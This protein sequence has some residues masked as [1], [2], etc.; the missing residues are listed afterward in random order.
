MSFSSKTKNELSRIKFDD[1]CCQRSELSAL[2]R[3]S[4]SIQ[5][6]GFKKVNL[7]ITTE[8]AAVARH[9]FTLFKKTFNIHAEVHVKKN[10]NLKKSNSYFIFFE[11]AMELL[12]TLEIIK[13]KNGILEINEDVPEFVKKKE[14]CKRA[15][16]RG[17]FIGGGSISDPE[18]AYHLELNLHSEKF[19]SMLKAFIEDNYRIFPKEIIRKNNYV[20]Y[21]KEGDQIS[22]FLN[23]I[24]AH[25]T[26]L[27]FENIRVVKQMRNNVNR[28]VNCET[29]NLNKT[30]DA[31]IR[32][33][34]AI[35]IIRDTVGFESLPENLRTLAELR[36]ENKDASLKELGEMLDP[37]IGKSGVNHRLRKLENIA[38]E[39]DNS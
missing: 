19:C 27:N 35:E 7:Q 6:M 30:V 12:S 20:L 38:R 29:A 10:K 1:K 11:N 31:A 2:I 22:D 36:I 5:L 18:K 9:I 4:G 25:G 23:I 33:V 3:V 26:L 37:P 39:L 28:I 24:G 21:F 13:K 14:C 32:Q 15:Y 34:K 8:N 17:I 16:L